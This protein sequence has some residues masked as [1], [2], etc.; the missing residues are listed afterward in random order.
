MYDL[1][2]YLVSGAALLTASASTALASVA[3]GAALPI[4]G[5]GLLAIAAAGVVG[6]VWLARR[7][8]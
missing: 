6:G 3:L 8:R 2:K 7:K 4:G 1:L 5:A